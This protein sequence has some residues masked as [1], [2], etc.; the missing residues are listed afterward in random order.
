M[1]VTDINFK[2]FMDSPTISFSDDSL[3]DHEYTLSP[4]TNDLGTMLDS[5]PYLYDIAPVV[6]NQETD[7][8][9]ITYFKQRL[10]NLEQSVASFSPYPQSDLDSHN[11]GSPFHI[12][13]TVP[14]ETDRDIHSSVPYHLGGG[15]AS[16]AGS[17][18]GELSTINTPP[19]SEQSWPSHA[20]YHSPADIFPSSINDKLPYYAGSPAI[21]ST[22]HSSS[23]GNEPSVSP[24]D[25]QHYPDPIP[26]VITTYEDTVLPDNPPRSVPDFTNLHLATPPQEL[27]PH[28]TPD[29][30][31]FGQ[32]QQEDNNNGP[33]DPALA[34]QSIIQVSTSHQSLAADT[35]HKKG[36]ATSKKAE[37]SN[38]PA[39]ASSPGQSDSGIRKGKRKPK[40]RLSQSSQ[41]SIGKYAAA[42]KLNNSALPRSRQPTADRIFP[43]AFS[44]YG[45]TSAFA[46]KNEWKRHV[47]SQHLQIGFYRCDVGHCNISKR[48]ITTPSSS[49]CACSAS[50]SSPTS[51]PP[52]SSSSP[53]P[54]MR[55]P[56]DFNR[57]DLF[58][59]H[60]RR[61]HAP[62]LTSPA[63]HEPTKEERE[64]F[65]KQLEDVRKRCWLRQRHPP[66]HSQCPYCE[67]EF[68]GSHCWEDRM[69]HVGKHCETVD[70]E[71]RE[72]LALREWASKES[73]IQPYGNG[74]WILTSILNGHGKRSCGYS[75]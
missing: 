42:L 2:P 32:Q 72:D 58:T 66:Q 20:T 47:A 69:E 16:S 46:S 64:L 21:M 56:N 34:G 3:R 19:M 45:C 57:K 54:I 22:T 13:L 28:F 50:T 24:Q 39:S 30:R 6:L 15:Y 52:P 17:W 60:L 70:E 71:K 63:A 55:A 40:Q 8:S 43:C 35:P 38:S 23:D 37:R 62:W 48:P 33:I 9:R 41:R 61:M 11:S 31:M 75:S 1:T 7:A 74:K 49:S 14:G 29:N 26:H 25:V 36:N 67:L 68:S 44:N 51:S 65:D 27:P 4:H 18:G 10:S 59:Q 12:G 5:E 53:T 73:I